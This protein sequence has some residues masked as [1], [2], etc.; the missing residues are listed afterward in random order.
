MRHNTQATCGDILW[1]NKKRNKEINKSQN[2]NRY[3]NDKI[4]NRRNREKSNTIGKKRQSTQ[5]MKNKKQKQ[6]VIEEKEADKGEAKNEKRR[7]AF[8]EVELDIC[9]LASPW[10]E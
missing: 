8:N 7:T 10:D 2:N 3:E 6:N 5:C 4:N 1:G 9:K